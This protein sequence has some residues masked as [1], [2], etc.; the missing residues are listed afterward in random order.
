L[1]ALRRTAG[2]REAA[3]A[4]F[5][6]HGSRKRRIDNDN[7]RGRQAPRGFLPK[8]SQLRLPFD[9]PEPQAEG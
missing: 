5:E 8:S 9:E 4:V 6:K 7:P 2:Y 1:T 3:L